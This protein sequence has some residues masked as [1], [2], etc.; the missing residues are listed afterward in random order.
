MVFDGNSSNKVVDH[1]TAGA[2]ILTEEIKQM[3]K[4]IYPNLSFLKEI[5]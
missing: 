4:K 3:T 5:L 1:S 2:K